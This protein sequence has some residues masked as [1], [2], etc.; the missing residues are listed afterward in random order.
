MLFITA[1]MG[2][3]TGTGAAPI[4]AQIA[5]ELDILTVGIVTLPFEFEGKAKMEKALSGVEELKKGCDSVITILKLEFIFV[6]SLTN[7]CNMSPIGCRRAP[8]QPE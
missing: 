1:G 7:Y 5:N 2:G 4:I 3:G 8:F 6:C